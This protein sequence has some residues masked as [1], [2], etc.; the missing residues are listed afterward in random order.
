MASSNPLPDPVDSTG[1]LALLTAVAIAIAA[2]AHFFLNYP[3]DFIAEGQRRA[4]LGLTI[5]A[6]ALLAAFAL[7]M[8]VSLT[9]RNRPPI[10]PIH[11]A[12]A[13]V[14]VTLAAASALIGLHIE[15]DYWRPVTWAKSVATAAALYVTVFALGTLFWQGIVQK[16]LLATLPAPTRPL[17]TA[18]LGLLLWLPFAPRT[19]WDTAL[20]TYLLDY[21]ILYLALAILFELGLQLRWVIAAS[22]L[23]ALAY[24]WG[25]QGIFY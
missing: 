18:A 20:T 13:A 10:N 25:H 3:T 4:W 21:T 16:R 8:E 1:K 9:E 7:F 23:I 22:T 11:A 14:L 5:W 24:T 12:A 17:L 19:G 6:P 15:T 2:A